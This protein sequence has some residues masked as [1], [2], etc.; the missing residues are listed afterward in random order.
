ME[1]TILKHAASASSTE[2]LLS[3]IA[4]INELKEVHAIEMATVGQANNPIW[5]DQCKGRR[6][7]SNFY[8]VF[9]RMETIK[10]STEGSVD[11][12]NL[13]DHLLGCN[14]PPN[15]IQALKYGRNMETIARDKYLSYFK[16]TT[17]CQLL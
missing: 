2:E 1:N 13:V 16:K 10:S 12:Q 14:A 3:S 4:P 17:K 8:R 7:V 15:D 11:P 6:T 5:S 9:T